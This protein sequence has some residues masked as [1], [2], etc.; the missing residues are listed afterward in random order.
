LIPAPIVSAVVVEPHGAHP[1]FAQGY[2]D[3][4]NAFYLSW[5]KIAKDPENLKKY[6]DEFVYS[7]E[8]RQAYMKKQEGLA[9]KLKADERI[10]AGVNY[11]F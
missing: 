4:D 1:S 9:E 11:G 10:C 3:R 8:D 7:V 2:Y 5:D 6:L